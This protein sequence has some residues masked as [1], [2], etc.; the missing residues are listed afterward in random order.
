MTN[1]RSLD[2]SWN[3]PLVLTRSDAHLFADLVQFENLTMRAWG[4]CVR[5]EPQGQQIESLFES[6]FLHDIVHLLPHSAH[7]GSPNIMKDA[8]T[9]SGLLGAYG[10]LWQAIGCCRHKY[11]WT[12]NGSLSSP[13]PA[14]I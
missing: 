7:S 12:F 6:L 5:N 10:C 13:L 9:S 8:I 4:D 2:V 11:C 14:Y 3:G 1:L